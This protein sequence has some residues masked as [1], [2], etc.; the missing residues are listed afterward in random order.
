MTDQGIQ[1]ALGVWKIILM[2]FTV[3]LAVAMVVLVVHGA[4]EVV[5]AIVRRFK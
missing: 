1:W 4:A 3:Q 2:P 5:R